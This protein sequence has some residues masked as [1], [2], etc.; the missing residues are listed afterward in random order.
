MKFQ[1]ILSED[2]FTTMQWKN[3]HNKYDLSEKQR[4]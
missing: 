4:E 1:N 3:F 2:K